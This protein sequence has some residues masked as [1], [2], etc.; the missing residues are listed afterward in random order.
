MSATPILYI[1][2]TSQLYNFL[3]MLKLSPQQIAEIQAK[4]EKGNLKTQDI[5]KY[6]PYPNDKQLSL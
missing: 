6:T 2:N 4:G 1:Q 5:L 3:H